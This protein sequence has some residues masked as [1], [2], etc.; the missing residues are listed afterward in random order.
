VK[1]LV[2]LA[3]MVGSTVIG[4][5]LQSLE[6]KR[7]GEIKEFH[8]RGIG[9]VLA[10][11]AQRKFLILAIAF[12]AVSF[13]AFMTL[14]ESTDLSVAVPA[15]AATLVFETILARIVLK[16]RVDSRRWA[17]A[18]LVAFGVALLAK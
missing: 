12:M 2:L 1:A 16:E 4:D 17:G 14:L 5:L 6:M 9:R 7:H 11:L 18:C 3:T 8:P 15:S 10:A 13:F